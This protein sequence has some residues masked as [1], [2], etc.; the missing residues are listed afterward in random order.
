[1]EVVNGTGYVS[2]GKDL[3]P[4]PQELLPTGRLPGVQLPIFPYRIEAQRISPL[5]KFTRLQFVFHIEYR[6]TCLSERHKQL[7]F[8]IRKAL[9]VQGPI[10]VLDQIR[11]LFQIVL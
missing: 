4:I 7:A 2:S 3:D 1:M 6:F 8:I 10:E 11:D 5:A 9:F